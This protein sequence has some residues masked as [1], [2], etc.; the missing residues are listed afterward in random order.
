[1]VA[2]SH[3]SVVPEREAERPTVALGLAP[4]TLHRAIERVAAPFSLRLEWE[5]AI[6]RFVTRIE[7]ACPEFLIV[8]TDLL[9]CL[10]DLCSFA[11]SLRPDVRIFG[12]TWYWSERDD[13]LAGCADALLHKPLRRA[14][15][16]SVFDRAGIL[17]LP[18]P[19]LA[20]AS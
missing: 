8:D 15:W 12:L 7:T 13:A 18:V 20:A 4:L 2:I 9:G 19:L 3:D 5:T 1:M 16:E 6:D 14:Q 10:S 11:R 17:R